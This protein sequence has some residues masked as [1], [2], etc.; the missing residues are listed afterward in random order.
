M[1][2]WVTRAQPGADATARR[3]REL[4]HEPIV[5][6]VLEVRPLQPRLDVDGVG[7]LAFTSANGVRAFAALTPIRGWPVYAVGG[8]T[9]DA[10]RAAGFADVESADGDIGD[11]HALI[12]AQRASLTGVLLHP[13]AVL[14]AGDLC[15]D[16]A[17]VGIAARAVAVYETVALPID[18][19]RVAGVE[20]VLIHSPRAGRAVSQTP[21]VARLT[22][23]CISAAA[24]APLRAAGA[25]AIAVAAAPDEAALLALLDAA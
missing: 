7:A 4:G 25:V 3:L 18:A 14:L 10:A 8:A 22:A 5:A 17:K 2:I 6:P 23:L 12:L 21:E 15:G 24:A 1:R 11:L 16:L 19:A 20:A 13:G 9:A